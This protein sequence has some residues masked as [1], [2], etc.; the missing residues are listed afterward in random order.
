VSQPVAK[1]ILLLWSL[2]WFLSSIHLTIFGMSATTLQKYN[3]CLQKYA[4][5]KFEHVCLTASNKSRTAKQDCIKLRITRFLDFVERPV[6]KRNREHNVSET[7]SVSVFRVK[8]K[9]PTLLGPL[10]RA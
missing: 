9:T 6:F 2:A 10:E 8:G 1:A 4:Y 5:F 3:Y 7:E